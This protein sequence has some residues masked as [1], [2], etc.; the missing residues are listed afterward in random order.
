[1]ASKVVKPSEKKSGRLETQHQPDSGSQLSKDWSPPPSGPPT[2][3][4]QARLR[5]G[6]CGTCMREGFSRGGETRRNHSWIQIP[7]FGSVTRSRVS[8]TYTLH[9]A[10]VGCSDSPPRVQSA[11]RLPR[12]SS[13]PSAGTPVKR[14]GGLHHG[15][16]TTSQSHNPP[17]GSRRHHIHVSCKRWCDSGRGGQEVGG[18]GLHAGPHLAILHPLTVTML[19]SQRSSS[20][21]SPRGPALALR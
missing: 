16:G 15:E 20:V 11:R 21:S 2:G 12:P 6:G 3:R 7:S 13:T 9:S 17:W 10:L 8:S 19:T 18:N 14:G 1:M 4:W 5:P